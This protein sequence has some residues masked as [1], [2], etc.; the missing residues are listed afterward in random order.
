MPVLLDFPIE[1]F[2]HLLELL[3]LVNRRDAINCDAIREGGLPLTM[4]V[5]EVDP[6]TLAQWTWVSLD[7]TMCIAC[8]SGKP[9]INSKERSNCAP[10]SIADMRSFCKSA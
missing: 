8:I 9:D 1:F 6:L 2:R 5:T 3:L 7:A 4:S 10:F